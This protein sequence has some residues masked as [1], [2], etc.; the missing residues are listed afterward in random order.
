MTLSEYQLR[1]LWFDFIKGLDVS[2]GSMKVPKHIFSE[3][4]ELFARG[5]LSGPNDSLIKDSQPN[6]LSLKYAADLLILLEKKNC[7][8]GIYVDLNKLKIGLLGQEKDG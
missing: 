7:I 1:A 3:L 5:D 6:P 2:K 4:F 8:N